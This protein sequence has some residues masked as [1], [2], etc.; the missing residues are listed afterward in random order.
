LLLVALVAA[1][2]AFGANWLSRI[3][4]INSW[5]ALI[6]AAA[7]VAIAFIALVYAFGL[8][9]AERRELKALLSQRLTS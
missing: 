4:L 9:P 6:G 5:P 2:T 3:W 7:L 1:G 8:R